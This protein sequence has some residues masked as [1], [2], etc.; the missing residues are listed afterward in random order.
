MNKSSRARRKNMFWYQRI[1]FYLQV[2]PYPQA[3]SIDDLSPS[4]NSEEESD[5]KENLKF[6]TA[7]VDGDPIQEQW[8]DLDVILDVH[9]VSCISMRAQVYLSWSSC[10]SKVTIVGS[11]KTH[12]TCT[13]LLKNFIFSHRLG[14]INKFLE[15][16]SSSLTVV[17]IVWQSSR[18]SPRDA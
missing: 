18:R 4:G 6:A 15:K 2:E 14:S 3:A 11:K 13:F 10:A 16:F 8:V 9:S 5:T 7:V 1:A 12:T 17:L